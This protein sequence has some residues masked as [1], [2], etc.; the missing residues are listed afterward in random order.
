MIF[1]AIASLLSVAFIFSYSILS[2]VV[3]PS[4]SWNG[5]EHVPLTDTQK[6]LRFAWF[7]LASI[8]PFFFVVIYLLG[9][10]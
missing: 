6:R 2:T 4:K 10:R 5:K 3:D 8:I 9:V 7:A 1:L